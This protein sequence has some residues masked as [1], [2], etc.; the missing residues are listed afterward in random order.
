MKISFYI[1]YI[2]IGIDLFLKMLLF[3]KVK[4][5]ALFKSQKEQKDFVYKTAY[6]WGKNILNFTNTT[7]EVIGLENVPKEPVV[8]ISNHQSTVD[9]PL[10]LKILPNQASFVAK[11]ELRKTPVVATWMEIMGCIFIDRKSARAALQSFKEGAEMIKKGQSVIIFPEGT[12]T[13]EM[14][15]FKKGSFKLATMAKVPIL[16][17]T[18]VGSEKVLADGNFRNRENLVKV[19]INK[20]VDLSKLEKPQ[21]N[22]IH[23]DIRNIIIENFE[24]Y[25]Q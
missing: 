10:L 13:P 23:E 15:P 3:P 7:V 5:L 24:K 6:N 9:I 25:K 17:V 18:I 16:P 19:I 8:V 22:V 14:L 12:R 20:P 2:K 21:L 4:Y 1:L 11:I